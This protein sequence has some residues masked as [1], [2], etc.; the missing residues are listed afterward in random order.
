MTYYLDYNELAQ[1]MAKDQ[2]S[3]AHHLGELYMVSDQKNKKKILEGF[4]EYFQRF[5]TEEEHI[6]FSFNGA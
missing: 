2:S 4:K 1:R 5:M 3:F 6:K